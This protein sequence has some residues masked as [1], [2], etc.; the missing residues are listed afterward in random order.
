MSTNFT[1]LVNQFI[2]RYQLIRKGET[3]IVGLSGGADSVALLSVL[4]ESGYDI[5]AAHCNFHLRGNES[6]RD[7]KFCQNLCN[8]LGIKLVIKSFDVDSRCRAHGESVEMACRALRYEWWREMLQEMGEGVVAVGHHREDNIETFF[9][10]LLRG[11]SLKGLKGMLPYNDKIVRPLLERSKDEIVSYL[12]DQALDHIVDSSNAD[13]S[14]KRN[15]LR[16]LVLPFIEQE[17][18][19]AMTSIGHTIDHLRD[20][21][22]LYKSFRQELRDKYIL[23]GGVIDIASLVIEQMNPEV[24]LF[25]LL[26]D[27]GFNMTQIRDMIDRFRDEDR[28]RTSGKYFYGNDRCYLL[29]RGKLFP[30]EPKSDDGTDKVNIDLCRYPFSSRTLTHNE[31]Q[32]LRERNDLNPQALYVDSTITEGNPMF[33]M[34]HWQVGDRMRPFGLKGSKLLSDI[35]SNAKMSVEAKKRVMVVIRNSEIIWIPGVRCSAHFPVTDLTKTVLEVTYNPIQMTDMEELLIKN[36]VCHHCVKAVERILCDI[37][38]G[39]FKVELGK[40]VLNQPLS[41]DSKEQF[42]LRLQRDGFDLITDKESEIVE[43]AKHAILHHVRDEQEKHHNLSDCIER[44][45]GM[46]YDTVSRIFS[47]REGR[48]M[49][50]YHIAQRIERVKELLQHD[51]YTLSEIAYMM[52]YSSVAHLSR[53]F[54][55]VTG[56]TP[57]EYLRGSRER[58]GLHEI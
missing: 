13:N 47:A 34:R 15:R 57:S 28:S 40:A 46:S 43:K 7:E 41:A 51:E 17:F 10:N 4:H 27:N 21:F 19:E 24:I 58:R 33:L 54:K 49:E 20:N 9:L 53:Q 39:E 8:R 2:D 6:M 56:M 48:T 16:N 35:F 44:Q 42:K 3:V 50:K 52:D 32:K 26:S 18:P 1:K 12:K 31:F 38:A 23:E 45:L 11:S 36:M 22:T 25:E 14:Y 37:G 5:L 55:S 30:V 29:D